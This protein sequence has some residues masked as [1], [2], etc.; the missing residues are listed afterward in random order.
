MEHLFSEIID[1]GIGPGMGWERMHLT[2]RQEKWLALQFIIF[3]LLV[4]TFF[5]DPHV[6][7]PTV[8]TKSFD[9]ASNLML[10]DGPIG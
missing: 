3:N 9:S 8:G 5:S 2:V 6:G 1:Q 4:F 7:R 10:S